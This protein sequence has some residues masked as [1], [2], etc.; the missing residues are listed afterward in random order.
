M[1]KLEILLLVLLGLCWLALIGCIFV[2]KGM[3]EKK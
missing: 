3:E 2:I 1:S